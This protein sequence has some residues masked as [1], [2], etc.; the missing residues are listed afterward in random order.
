MTK[1]ANVKFYDASNS[2]EVSAKDAVRFGFTCPRGRGACYGLLIA[3]RTNLK[4]SP[5]GGDGGVPMWDLKDDT[6][7]K[8]TF[9]PSINCK[10]CWHGYIRNGQC[11]DA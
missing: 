2:K 9:H 1:P 11:V 3:G 10:D 4:R 8:E 7:G 6:P 5:K